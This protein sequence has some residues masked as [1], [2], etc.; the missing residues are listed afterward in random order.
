MAVAAPVFHGSLIALDQVVAPP[1]VDMPD[2]VEMR[3]V[4]MIDVTNDTPI[5]MGFIGTDRD[6]AMQP[7]A[8]Y[9]FVRRF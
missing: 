5:G 4:P 2:A 1:F 9:G 7:Y 6:R 8:F 3:V